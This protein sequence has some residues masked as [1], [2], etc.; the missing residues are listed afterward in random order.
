MEEAGKKNPSKTE[1]EEKVDDFL[2][3]AFGKKSRA[4]LI[5]IIG[6]CMAEYPELITK[7]TQ[8]ED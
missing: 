6:Y 3:Q 8:K 7:L 4:Q 2:Q 1:V 5:Q